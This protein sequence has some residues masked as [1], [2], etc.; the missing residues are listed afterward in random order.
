[1]CSSMSYHT[2]VDD[3]AT[4]R[5]GH[6]LIQWLEGAE[7]KMVAATYLI[8]AV[9]SYRLRIMDVNTNIHMRGGFE[10]DCGMGKLSMG[11]IG[12]GATLRPKKDDH[13]PSEIRAHQ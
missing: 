8:A 10:P 5:E 6:R 9:R 7:E 2:R 3:N 13:S 12:P 11:G 4:P 1:M